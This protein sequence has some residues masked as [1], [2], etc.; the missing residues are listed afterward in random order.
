MDLSRDI[1]IRRFEGGEVRS[2]GDP[3]VAERRIELDV[4]DGRLR[5]GMLV[6]PADLEAMAVG[7]LLGE[8]V[9]RSTADLG[10][11][12]FD[13]DAG[14]IRVRGDF[15]AEALDAIARRWTWGSGCGGGGTG[16]DMDA[17]AYAPVGAGPEVSAETLLARMAEFHRRTSLWKITGGVHACALAGAAGVVLL[18]EDIGRHNAFD[19]VMGA[20]ALD[21]IELAN[22]FVLT[23]G[24]LSAEI[25]SKA[26]ACRV[27]LLASR[28]AVTGLGVQL[29]RRFGVTLVGFARG[30]RL[31]VYTGF[32]RVVPGRS[33][34][35]K[36]KS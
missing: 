21:G 36:G 9:L 4:N 11:V 22:K 20:A 29:A 10:E 16:R 31:N 23:T 1:P 6:L 19:K 7:F 34:Q 28:G 35:P 8:G 27:G 14:V 30:R 26:V 12:T 25:V 15:D 17:A 33:G 32:E 3:V 13:A 24:R 5:L 18:A 2:V